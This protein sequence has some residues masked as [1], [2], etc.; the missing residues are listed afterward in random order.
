MKAKPKLTKATAQPI[1]KPKP[2]QII[3]APTQYTTTKAQRWWLTK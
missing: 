2:N 3:T 1:D